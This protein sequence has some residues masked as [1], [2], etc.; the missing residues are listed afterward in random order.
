MDDPPNDEALGLRERKKME[1]RAALTL[2]AVRLSARRGFDKVL[3][4]DIAAEAG[5]SP[6]TFNNYF[7]SKA[8]AIAARHLDRL[9]AVAHALRARPARE[10]LWEAIA[11]SVVLQ[12]HSHEPVAH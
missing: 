9:R 5:V 7:A 11:S 8:E 4:E 1:T 2:A 12:F 3:V 10:P 6:R